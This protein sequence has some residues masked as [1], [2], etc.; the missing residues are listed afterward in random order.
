MV[1]LQCPACGALFSLELLANDEAAREVVTLAFKMPSS[2]RNLVVGYL[3]L[4]RP[5][6]SVLSWGK[7]ARLLREM[8]AAMDGG[9]IERG[10]KTYPAPLPYWETALEKVIA[11]ARAGK[12]DRPLHGHGYLYQ[13]LAGQSE[14]GE[15]RREA[16]RE[17]QRKNRPQ[18]TD[19]KG[20]AK[21]MQTIR[22][23]L[24]GQQAKGGA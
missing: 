8:A 22:E 18:R 20:A 6:K 16:R 10:G 5:K 7:A 21:G 4:H 23:A 12:I 9:S 19:K 24:L 14:Q 2:V 15:A 1:K 11:N 13:V 3:A 17:Q